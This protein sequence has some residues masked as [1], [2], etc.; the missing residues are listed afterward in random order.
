MKKVYPFLS[1]LF[2]FL[3]SSSYSHGDLACPD[4]CNSCH[5]S[6]FYDCEGHTDVS[7]LPRVQYGIDID[8]HNVI[9][10]TKGHETKKIVL[11]GLLQTDFQYIRTDDRQLFWPLLTVGPSVPVRDPYEILQFQLKRARLGLDIDLGN[12]WSGVIEFGLGLCACTSTCSD[13]ASIGYLTLSQAYIEKIY[14]G[15]SFKIGYRKVNFG[16]EKVIHP[17]KLKT[18]ERSVATNYFSSLN[19]P[20]N[21]HDNDGDSRLALGERH[22]GLF[23]DGEYEWIGYGGAVTNSFPG[24]GV[25]STYS[26]ELS[27]YGNLYV[28]KD[29]NGIGVIAGSNFVYKPEGN[30]SWVN[31]NLRSR[32]IGWNPYA[33]IYWKDITLLVEGLGA[34]VANGSIKSSNS[35]SKAAK[36]VG[37][38]VIFSYRLYDCFELV[39]RYTSI[40][41]DQRGLRI[42][43]VAFP[44]QNVLA[45]AGNISLASQTN[46]FDEADGFYFGFNLYA[47]NEAV[48]LSAGYEHLTFQGRWGNSNNGVPPNPVNDN[49]SGDKAKVD[50]VRARIQIVF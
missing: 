15:N 1:I 3:L 45:G 41:T 34:H 46:I 24:L 27:V 21:R 26:N 22:V 23:I 35:N 28:R 10:G 2:L 37:Y 5:P 38:N 12:C 49:F 18:I 19:M 42:Y 13:S 16:A 17:A 8:N 9:F 25:S 40:D 47:L 4:P 32:I 39:T 36:P 11:W 6:F 44:A 33:S 29:L 20:C 50:A 7:I 48:K 31:L 30:S 43:N 14:S